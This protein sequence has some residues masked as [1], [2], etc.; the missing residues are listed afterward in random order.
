M[1]VNRS[2]TDRHENLHISLVLGHA[3]KATFK[4]IYPTP[5]QFGVGKRHISPTGRQSEA[6][7]FEMAQHIDKQKYISFI[8][9][10]CTQNGIKL[11]ASPNGV[12]MQ[13]REKGLKK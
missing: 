11:G 10:K 5:K 13:P 1:D 2:L 8:Y 12:L 6:R 9:D 4:K 3:S 7:N